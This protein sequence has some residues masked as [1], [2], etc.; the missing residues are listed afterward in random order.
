MSTISAFL[1]LLSVLL[2]H[3]P[4][5]AAQTAVAGGATP[6][7]VFEKAVEANRRRDLRSLVALAH[8]CHFLTPPGRET[9]MFTGMEVPFWKSTRGT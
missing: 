5:S 2:P 6:E 9:R 8:V 3:P 7:E 4:I 1:V